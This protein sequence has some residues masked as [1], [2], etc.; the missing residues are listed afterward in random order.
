MN[1]DRIDVQ[2]PSLICDPTIVKDPRRT[3][4]TVSLSELQENF[5]IKSCIGIYSPSCPCGGGAVAV[6]FCGLE[7]SCILLHTGTALAAWIDDDQGIPSPNT[8]ALILLVTIQ[9]TRRT[10]E[11]ADPNA[12]PRQSNEIPDNP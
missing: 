3:H 12:N 6:A 7:K 4:T 8:L 10:P 11:A 5:P 2:L 1:S 9:Y